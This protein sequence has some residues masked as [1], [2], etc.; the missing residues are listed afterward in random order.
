MRASVALVALS[1][2]VL[3]CSSS[4]GAAGDGGSLTQ[5]RHLSPEQQ[6]FGVILDAKS[7]RAVAAFRVDNPIRAAIPDGSGGWYI[8]GGF[9]HVN[10]VLRKRLAH[11]DAGGR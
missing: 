7:G 2:L 8:G 1:V 11:I 5:L 10:G 4:R 9:V 6:N 3:A